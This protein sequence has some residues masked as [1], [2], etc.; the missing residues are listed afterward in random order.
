MSIT[1]TKFKILGDSSGNTAEVDASNQVK[2]IS[3]SAG[4]VTPGTVATKSNLIGGQYNATL[5]TLTDTQQAAAQVDSRGR[6]LVA[7]SSVA[8][9]VAPNFSNK[10][11]GEATFTVIAVPSSVT[12]TTIYTYSG[13]GYFVGFN[14][15]YNNTGIVIKL[16]IDGN[17]VFDGFDIGQ[18][19][20]LAV[21]SNATTRYQAG[22][23]IISS[24]SVFDFS[25]K[26]PIA[27]S[28]SVVISSRLTSGAISRNFQQGIVYIQKDT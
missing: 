9:T 11:K 15:E 2:V 7:I 24:S 27:Y 23:G 8:A 14:H 10:I 12:Y 26:Y 22:Q 19:N 5:P 25:F 21:T 18:Y 3:P 17:T 4:P 20:T 13:S 1:T 6:M 16:V 28:S